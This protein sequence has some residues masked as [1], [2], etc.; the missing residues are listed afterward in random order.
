[1]MR[2]AW[3]ES[4]LM[5]LTRIWLD[6]SSIRICSIAGSSLSSRGSLAYRSLS[7]FV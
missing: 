5:A 6:S 4:W 7:C 1:M 3:G 2:A